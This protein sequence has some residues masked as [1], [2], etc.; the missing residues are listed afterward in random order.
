[1]TDNYGPCLFHDYAA[2]DTL[3][4]YALN[5][6]WNKTNSLNAFITD[7]DTAQLF[8]SELKASFNCNSSSIATHDCQNEDRIVWCDMNKVALEDLSVPKKQLDAY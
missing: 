5:I 4:K 1:M 8:E 2:I 6:C 3:V 7:Y